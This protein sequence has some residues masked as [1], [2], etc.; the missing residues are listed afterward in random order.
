MQQAPQL[1]YRYREFEIALRKEQESGDSYRAVASTA[2]GEELSETFTIPIDPGELSRAVASIRPAGSLLQRSVPEASL[3]P[4]KDIGSRLF[5]ALFQASIG[6]ELSR[7]LRSYRDD[8]VR[9][10]LVTKQGDGAAS[11]PW[12]FLY[13]RRRDD[14]LVLSTRSP[15]VRRMVTPGALG[16]AEPLKP[17][18]RILV[19]VADVTGRNVEAELETIESLVESR[20]G[21][22]EI[23]AKVDAAEISTFAEAVTKTEAH[24][25]H[26]IAM[27]AD[28][29]A[30]G[31]RIAL[32]PDIGK[33]SSKRQA[34]LASGHFAT[35][36]SGREHLRC[37]LISAG[38]T[39]LVA[40]AVAQQQMPMTI[41]QRGDLSDGA[42]AAFAEGFYAALLGGSSM[43]AAVTGG[44][45]AI[46]SKDPGGREWS[47]P[48]LYLQTTDGAFL[49][50]EAEPGRRDSLANAERSSREALKDVHERNLEAL[51]AGLAG[52]E[53]PSYVLEQI[54]LATRESERLDTEIEAAV[55][56]GANGS[57]E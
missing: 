43:E 30:R 19:A 29:A 54:A 2:D 1:T 40:S 50:A 42:A 24:L 22:A 8:G 34:S 23:V 28:E 41:G 44:R 15:L 7:A 46:D 39:D 51:R 13:D 21:V 38:H 45:L 33:R 17:P 56:G 4:V 47:A 55:P 48:V 11:V 27:G 52:E 6:R 14:F 25:V 31:Q 9:V 20:P 49:A 53:A 16:P 35:L 12:E 32:L 36:V 37:L 5:D 26:L 57:R 3:D 10:C 18:I